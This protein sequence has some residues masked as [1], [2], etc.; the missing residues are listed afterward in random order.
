[1]V[2]KMRRCSW[3]GIHWPVALS[4][5]NHDIKDEDNIYMDIVDIEDIDMEILDIEDI[6]DED[7]AV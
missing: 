2:M 1:M 6:G 5:S 4:A 7:E 3:G